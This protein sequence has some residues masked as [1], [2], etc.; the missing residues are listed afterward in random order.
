MN[1]IK[2]IDLAY[3]GSIKLNHISKDVEFVG[4]SDDQVQA[5]LSAIDEFNKDMD[6]ITD[7]QIKQCKGLLPKTVCYHKTV[8]PCVVSSIN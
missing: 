7:D 5:V 3:H 2:P 6:R 1:D 4:V 8:Q